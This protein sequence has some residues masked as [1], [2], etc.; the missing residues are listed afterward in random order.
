MT[1][2]RMARLCEV[3]ERAAYYWVQGQ[4]KMPASAF[5]VIA[6]TLAAEGDVRLIELLL[7]NE[8][9]IAIGEHCQPDGSIEDEATELLK[10]AGEFCTAY[11]NGDRA[12]MDA[13]LLEIKHDIVG[14]EQ[15]KKLRFS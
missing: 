9:H 5:A 14:F 10:D 15:E 6:F 11:A 13:K 3:E 1:V 7:P 12:T 8:Y 4:R 2:A